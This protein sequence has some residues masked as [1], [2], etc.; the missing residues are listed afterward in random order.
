MED[1]WKELSIFAISLEFCEEYEEENIN[2]I[3]LK[4][5]QG[6][7]VVLEIWT[8]TKSVE[9]AFRKSFVSHTESYLE[10]KLETIRSYNCADL[11]KSHKLKSKRVK[12]T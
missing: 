8:K 6:N 2:G 7:Q 4:V 12:K 3:S 11:I 5:K 1:L 10:C 9:E